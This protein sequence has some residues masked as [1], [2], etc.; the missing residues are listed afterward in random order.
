MPQVEDRA[1]HY[2]LNI[3]EVCQQDLSDTGSVIG[4]AIRYNPR[5]DSHLKSKD[6][7]QI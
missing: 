7:S 5:R 6:L 3:V 4:T 1:G 2:E